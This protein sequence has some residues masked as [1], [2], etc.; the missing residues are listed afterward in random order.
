[1]ENNN[2]I[3]EKH[4]KIIKERIILPKCK[5]CELDKLPDTSNRKIQA[6]KETILKIDGKKYS[7]I[8]NKERNN[9]IGAYYCPGLEL[10][11]ERFGNIKRNYS[12]S[13]DDIDVSDDIDDI[14]YGCG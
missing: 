4:K 3:C 7:L 2:Y 6:D 9:G 12:N 14:I 8:W 11:L 10:Y 5:Y 1:M 13:K